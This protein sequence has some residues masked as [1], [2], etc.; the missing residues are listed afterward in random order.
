MQRFSLFLAIPISLL[1]QEER[2]LPAAKGKI[3]AEVPKSIVLQGI[4]RDAGTQ[5]PLPGA[6]IRVKGTVAGTVS[7]ADG[8]F[9]LS[10]IGTF[11]VIIEVSYVGY[12]TAELQVSQAAPLEI[13][14]KEGGLAMKDV[15]ISTSRV[16]EAVLEA[17]VTVS[18]L[19]IRELQMGAAA[20]LFQQLATMKNVDVQYQSITFPVI[21]TRGFASS[22]NPRLVQRIDGIEMLAPVLGFPVGLLSAPSDIDLERA[23][24]T[25]GPASALYGPNAFNGMLDMYTRL[26]RQYPGLSASIR[27]GFNH[28]NSDIS[29]RPYFHLSA[30]Y[31][32]TLFE[33][34]SYKVVAEYLRATDWLATD[35][36]DEGSYVGA[37]S[38]YAIPGP[39]NPGYNGINTYGDEVRI[40]NADLGAL[41]GIRERFYVARTGY[42]D[43]DLISPEVFIQKYTLQMHYALTDRLELSWRSFLTNGNTIYQ[44]ANRNVLRDV[45]FHQHKIELRGRSFFLRSYGSWEAPGNAYDSRFTGIF[46]NQW[47]KPDVAWFI[48][49]HEGYAQYGS[50]AAARVYA[51]TVRFSPFYEELA[52]LLAPALPRGPFRRRLEPSDP[53]FDS[54]VKAINGGYLRTQKQAGFFD[55]SS[56]YHTEAQYDLSDL[57]GKY[58]ELLIG[59]NVRLFRVNSRGTLFADY[60]GPFWVREYGAFLQAN[61]WVLNRRLRLLGSLRYDKSQYFQGR[62]TP[63]LAALFAFGKERQ[64]NLRLS[65]QTGFRIPTLQDQF[66]ALDIGFN[67]M[68]L[69]GTS[70]TRPL[71]GVDKIAFDPF[72]VEAYRA[73]AAGIEDSATLAQFAQQLL[74]RRVIEPLRP[75]FVQQYEVGGRI[76]LFQGLYIDAEY[77]RVYYRDFILYRDVVSSQPIYETE[78]PRPVSLTNVDPSTYEGLINL[79]EGRFYTYSAAVNLPDEVYAD[80]GSVGI[81]YAITPKVL[82][83]ASYSYAALVLR[84]AQ[85]PSLFPNF[86]TPRHRVGSSLYVSGIGRWGGGLNYRWVDAFRMDGIIRGDVP[87]AQWIDLQ[88]SYTIPRWK[89]QLRVGGQNLLNVRYVQIPGGPRIGGLYYLQVVYDPFLR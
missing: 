13:A 87:A 7:G 89:T 4:V 56:F 69:G 55:R 32:Q 39:Q 59:G 63:R 12:E 82:W 86:N 19:G 65:Y 47:A 81:E 21:N 5:E 75:E 80:Y 31:A 11:P 83:T 85:D 30:R 88:V 25:T 50:H 41:F 36:R 15:V 16:P 2:A 35:Y 33:R 68:T 17:P 3:G 51:D 66:M 14:L 18:R 44:A 26:P 54:V 52:N 43:R 62:L 34:F 74:V 6:Y 46:L 9:R 60:E 28:L 40:L 49:Y 22:G 1:A 73:A 48:L 78:L 45:L 10:V 20:N 71:F 57:I 58:V 42:R 67:R 8:S 84:G 24:L 27:L 70:R 38:T 64:H 23:E 29:P 79:K 61:R 53:Q 76:Q 72:S 37:D 77:A